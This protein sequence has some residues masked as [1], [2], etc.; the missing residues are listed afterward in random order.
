M[1]M[2]VQPIQ[3]IRNSKGSN[4]Q[5]RS[6]R[7]GPAFTFAGM[8]EALSN[9]SEANSNQRRQDGFT[10][11]SEPKEDKVAHGLD[12]VLVIRPDILTVDESSMKML[13]SQLA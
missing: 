11:N 5:F 10:P 3:P 1:K 7:K 13:F 8:I 12:K 4:A 9:E 2:F 6:T